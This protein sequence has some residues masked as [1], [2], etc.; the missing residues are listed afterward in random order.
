M[1]PAHIGTDVA[2]GST[3]TAS[4]AIPSG[5]KHVWGSVQVPSGSANKANAV[6]QVNG[7]GDVSNYAS[8]ARG[9]FP[10]PVRPAT[11]AA[12][13]Y[14][15]IGLHGVDGG[16]GSLAALRLFANSTATDAWLDTAAVTDLAFVA[17]PDDA[18]VH[19]TSG[20]VFDWW[21]V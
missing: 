6:V 9:G 16:H 12:L 8:G 3:G 11:D 4:R 1:P 20:T 7:D 13:V 17:D 2:D 19:W 15:E 21:G 18:A 5:Y 14:A 10:V